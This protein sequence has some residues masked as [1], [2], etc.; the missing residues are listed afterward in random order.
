MLTLN[1]VHEKSWAFGDEKYPP[2]TKMIA[3][4]GFQTGYLE[5]Q[6]TIPS[7]CIGF[8]EWIEKGCYYKGQYYS[9]DGQ[10]A[11]HGWL[12]DGDLLANNTEELYSIYLESLKQ[13][14]GK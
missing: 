2:F 9:P 13:N 6:E 5:C 1:E 12:E 7:E 14:N 3:A 11:G 10:I 8:A 4:D